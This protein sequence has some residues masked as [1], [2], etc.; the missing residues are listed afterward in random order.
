MT[1]PLATFE[2]DDKSAP[3]AGTSY[4][5]GATLADRVNRLIAEAP[6]DIKMDLQRSLRAGY[7]DHTQRLA[8]HLNRIAGGGA[9]AP[10][11][12]DHAS[13]HGEG[14]EWGRN[15]SP[16]AWRYLKDHAAAYH[17]G[18][19]AGS[20]APTHMQAH[21]SYAASHDILPVIAYHESLGLAHKLGISP[22][23]IGYGGADLSHAPLD[24]SGFPI[25][26]G[27][28]GPAGISHAAGVGQMEPALWKET[29]DRHF[30]GHADFHDPEQQAAVVRAAYAD[31]GMRPW[32]SNPM[33]MARIGTGGSA[34]P[35]PFAY[36]D[37]YP[38]DTSAPPMATPKPAAP[39]AAAAPAATE[40]AL[41]NVILTPPTPMTTVPFHPIQGPHGTIGAPNL[42]NGFR[43]A[44]AA[45]LR[46]R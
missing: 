35:V 30:G 32:A 23:V 16:A 37:I 31:H 28:P 4:R 14:I 24:A 12:P 22:Y 8:A 21:E 41:G 43:Q 6:A 27:R 33:L 46:T 40:S 20:H 3:V 13:L 1:D 18:F 25:W 36:D 42:A 9:A 26:P 45:I 5:V 15:I 11:H 19:P 17:L 34:A 7:I 38:P 10:G 44:L 39:T 29:V 2:K